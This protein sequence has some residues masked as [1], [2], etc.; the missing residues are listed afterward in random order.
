MFAN[1]RKRQCPT[2][3]QHPVAER[4]QCLAIHTGTITNRSFRKKEEFGCTSLYGNV[5][6][7]IKIE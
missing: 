3:R 5:N 7:S 4:S 2:V 6:R 1:S